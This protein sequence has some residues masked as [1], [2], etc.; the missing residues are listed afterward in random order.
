MS[1]ALLH[2]ASLLAAVLGMGWLALA[3]DVH[4]Q[5]VRASDA[6]PSRKFLRALGHTALAGSLL[7]CLAADPATMA[8]LVWMMLLA[9]SA[10]TIAFV[11]SVRPRLL[12]ALVSWVS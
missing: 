7:L 6:Q 2:F 11:L 9:V 10:I 3:M 1:D 8:V 4:W 5:Q 12:A